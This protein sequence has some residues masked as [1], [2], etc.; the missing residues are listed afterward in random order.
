[1]RAKKY[2][3]GLGVTGAT[4]LR[5]IE[6]LQYSGQQL[7]GRYESQLDSKRCLYIGDSWFG[8]VKMAENLK[9]T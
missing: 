8:S 9:C 2:V 1:M 4:T 7:N 6:G 5:L 3:D